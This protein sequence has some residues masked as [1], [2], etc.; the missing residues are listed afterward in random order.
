M[1]DQRVP[2]GSGARILR[3]SDGS[4]VSQSLDVTAVLIE[5]T[6]GSADA[7]DRLLSFVYEE[8]RTVAERLLRGERRDHTL[9]ATDLVHEAYVRL[10]DV[11]RCRWEDR[12]H[13]LAV[14]ARAMRR[15]LVDHARGRGRAKRGSGLRNLSLDQALLIG[16]P[17]ADAML[18]ALEDALDNLGTRHPEAARVVEMRF[19]GG[20]TIEESASVLRCSPRMVSRHWEFAHAWLYREMS[21][22]DSAR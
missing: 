16:T 4:N 3:P 10:A 17:E 8:L 9:Q 5:S 1:V 11:T 7:T 22:D 19:F 13:F 15:I 20:L 2:E 6:N 14:A 18:L 12:A 21:T